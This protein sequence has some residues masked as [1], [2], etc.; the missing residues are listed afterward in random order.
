M[1]ILG[2]LKGIGHFL[3]KAMGIVRQIVPEELLAHAI[4][5]VKAARDKFLDNTDR[6]EWVVQELLKISING[7]HLPESVIRLAVELAVS[8]VKKETQ[9]VIDAANPTP[10]TV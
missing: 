6:R 2:F 1:D 4:E 7:V 5:L 8:I 10:G 3:A 9:S